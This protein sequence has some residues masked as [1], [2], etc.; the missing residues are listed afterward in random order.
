MRV[1]RLARQWCAVVVFATTPSAVATA[2]GL[3]AV[4][5]DSL[6][7]LARS[8]ATAMLA[9][10]GAR[11]VLRGSRAATDRSAAWA[12]L[13]IAAGTTGA[14]PNVLEAFI[15][16]LSLACDSEAMRAIRLARVAEALADVPGREEV[17]FEMA[18]VA[19]ADA[20]SR[21]PEVAGLAGLAMGK[22]QLAAGRPRDALATL[23][24]V[25]A[26]APDSQAVLVALSNAHERLG[27]RSAALDYAMRARA[28][29]LGADSTGL[30]RTRQLWFEQ[31]GTLNGLEA[32]LDT[33]RRESLLQVALSAL[34]DDGPEL[35]W[36]LPAAGGRV[37]KPAAWKG[38][39]VV[40][41]WWA[42]DRKSVV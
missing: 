21:S 39:V 34:R 2:A 42:P 16:S 28:A 7:T 13:A 38:R 20:G 32:R 9:V 17:A 33:L 8:P 1:A 10:T 22:A 15:D 26:R 36:T 11:G 12:I 23:Q 14:P 6:R 25:R 40:L 4:A 35:T 29:F 24:S 19:M 18:S 41:G 30:P 5:E 37:L 31:H 27:E 3:D